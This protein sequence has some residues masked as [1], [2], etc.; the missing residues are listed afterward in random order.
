MSST[1]VVIVLLFVF[2]M[3]TAAGGPANLN[4]HNTV[5]P[6]V[7]AAQYSQTDFGNIPG[8]KFSDTGEE[9]PTNR[10]YAFVLRQAKSVSIDDARMISDQIV[11]NCKSCDVNPF[12]ITALMARESRFNRYAISSSGAKGLGQLLD[13]TAHGMGVTDSYDISQN[14]M[15]TTKYVKSLLDRWPD[16][17]QGIP[18]ALGSYV[19][20]INGIKA[21]GRMSGEAAQYAKDIIALYWKI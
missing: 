6:E 19:E 15:G 10:I 21:K 20:G 1:A 3:F 14:A 17:D 12:L 8:K 2:S 11:E 5:A 7:I 4:S 18:L 9:D 16:N 13:S